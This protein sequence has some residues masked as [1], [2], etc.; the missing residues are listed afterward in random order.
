MS[1]IEFIPNWIYT[2]LLLPL[3][4]LFQRQFSI[5]SRV[6]VLES[7]QKIYVERIDAVCESNEILSKEVHQMLGRFDEFLRNNPNSG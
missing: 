5:K 6:T 4:L 2:V 1:E 7:T 3:A